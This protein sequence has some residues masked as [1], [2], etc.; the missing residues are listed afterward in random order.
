MRR[1]HERHDHLATRC[2]V[3]HPCLTP[4]TDRSSLLRSRFTVVGQPQ[5]YRN[6]GYLLV[7]LPLGTVWFTVLVSGLT[8]GSGVPFHAALNRRCGIGGDGGATATT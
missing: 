2:S 4:A 7:G 5:S 8:P 6:I 3:A 1:G